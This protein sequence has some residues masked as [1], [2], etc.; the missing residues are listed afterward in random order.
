[1]KKILN[2]YSTALIALVTILSIFGVLM[3]AS[4]SVVYENIILRHAVYVLVGY[5]FMIFFSFLT[6]LFSGDLQ[7]YFL[8]SSLYPLLLFLLKEE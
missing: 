6:T 5:C 3:S 7:R 4:L 1:M 8:F 2:P